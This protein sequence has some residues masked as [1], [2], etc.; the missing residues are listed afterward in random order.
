MTPL[1]STLMQVPIADLHESPLNPRKHFDAAALKELA[2]SISKVGIL[3]PLQARW[4]GTG[5][6]LAGGARRYRA[7]RQLGLLTVPCLVRTMTDAEFM[8]IM[9]VDNLQ[10]DNLHPLEEAQ[11]FKQLMEKSIGYDIAKIAERC[12]RSHQ[13]VYDRLRLLKLIPKAQDLFLDGRFPLSHAVLLARL[14]REDQ[15]RAIDPDARG[16]NGRIAG[17]F[18]PDDSLF[19]DDSLDDSKDPWAHTKPVSLGE[20]QSWINDHVRFDTHAD[21]VPDLFPETAAAVLFAEQNKQKVVYI[22]HDYRVADDAR[23]A[24][25]VRTYGENAWKRA[26]GTEQSKTCMHSVLGVVS[27]GRGRGDAFPV[28]VA[29]KKCEIHWPAEVRAEKQKAKLQAKADVGD[30]TAKAALERQKQTQAKEAEKA[31]AAAALR[32]RVTPLLVKATCAAIEDLAENK[33][34]ALMWEV[35]GDG[36]IYIDYQRRKKLKVPTSAARLLRMLLA[37]DVL[38]HES[39]DQWAYDEIFAQAKSVG[40]NVEKIVRDATAIEALKA[41][42]APKAK[43]KPAKAAKP[44]Q[45]AGK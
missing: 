7:A 36:E 29:K 15:E 11:G 40:V 25:G 22:T 27:A 35:L 34:V 33:L 19:D 1:D 26:D 13:Y 37:E 12:G 43:A 42:A 41:P 28:C 2:D 31:K 6:E 3:T 9:T 45:K 24:N 4:N 16:G 17:L 5:Y 21:V 32:A 23:D 8:E 14:S 44:K 20:F 18:Y 10:R 39:T 30:E 38:R